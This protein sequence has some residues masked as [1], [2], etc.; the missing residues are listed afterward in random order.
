MRLFLL[1][2]LLAV[3]PAFAQVGVIGDSF[4]DEYRAEDN[5]GGAYAATTLNWVELLARY[6]GVNLGAWGTL[7][8][9]S[10]SANVPRSVVVSASPVG[11]VL[12]IAV[13]FSAGADFFAGFDRVAAGQ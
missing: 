10:T 3:F 5:R 4:S 12:R 8:T 9:A 13:R 6:R 1:T 11:G 7:T 2:F